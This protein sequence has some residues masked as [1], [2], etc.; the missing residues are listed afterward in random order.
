[1]Y[2]D[3]FWNNL[4]EKKR[5]ARCCTKYSHP[6]DASRSYCQELFIPVR[7]PG[8]FQVGERGTISHF[9]LRKGNELLS[10]YFFDPLN[11]EF[12]LSWQ[13]YSASLLGSNEFI[14]DGAICPGPL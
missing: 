8:G 5:K 11:P 4:K 6:S 12:I 9:A 7:V 3:N 13:S 10:R 2:L 14:L 1:M